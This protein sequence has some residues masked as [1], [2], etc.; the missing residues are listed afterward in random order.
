MRGCQ[1]K[2][3]PREFGWNPWKHLGAKRRGHGYP[4]DGQI[5]KHDDGLTPGVLPK[6]LGTREPRAGK[7]A[8]AHGDFEQQNGVGCERGLRS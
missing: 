6:T 7:K 1:R 2:V 8:C 5:E 4:D 3:G